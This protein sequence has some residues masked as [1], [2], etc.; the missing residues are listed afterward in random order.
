[1]VVTDGGPPSWGLGQPVV[2]VMAAAAASVSC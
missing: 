2:A 1:M